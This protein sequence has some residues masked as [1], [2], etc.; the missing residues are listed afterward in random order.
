M[1]WNETF[2]G[3]KDDYGTDMLETRDGG[4][5]IT[6]YTLSYGTNGSYDIFLVKFNDTGVIQWNKTYGGNADEY[7]NFVRQTDDGGFIIT[8]SIFSDK[9][10]VCLIKT[11]GNGMLQWEK[12]Y[13][14]TYDAQGYSVQQTIDGGYIIAGIDGSSNYKMDGDFKLY[15]IKTDDNGNLIWSE[16]LAGKGMA[17]GFSVQQTKDG[18]YIVAGDT[19][20][21][22]DNETCLY[23]VKFAAK[24]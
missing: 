19:Q 11:D 5:I 10:Q 12:A 13:P 16:E 18:N 24:T 3:S 2:G 9:S 1:Q 14:G 15:L 4:Y 17:D 23:L 6:G 21:S 7:A 8:G 20:S 22:P